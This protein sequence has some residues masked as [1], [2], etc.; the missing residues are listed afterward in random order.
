MGDIS[1]IRILVV[2]SCLV[3]VFA[4]LLVSIPQPLLPASERETASISYPENWESGDLLY[5]TDTWNMTNIDNSTDEEF[6]LGGRNF[7]L[8]GYDS[9]ENGPYLVLFEYWFEWYVVYTNE[10]CQWL[11]STN[12]FVDSDF[13]NALLMESLDN[14]SITQDERFIIRWTEHSQFKMYAVLGYDTGTYASW[15][16]ALD[17]GALGLWLGVQFDQTNTASVSYTH[18][19]SPRDRS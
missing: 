18:L 2:V 11:D 6:E 8:R 19:P 1:E 4:F 13:Q 15:E 9:A 17:A 16:L 14:Q 10:P 5:L 7:N 12:Y 3:G